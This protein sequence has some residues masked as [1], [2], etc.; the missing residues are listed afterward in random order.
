MEA[1]INPKGSKGHAPSILVKREVDP[2]YRSFTEPTSV[3]GSCMATVLVEKQGY[4]AHKKTA[5]P[6]TLK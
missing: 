3:V 2:L 1:R 5:A 4:L 6:W